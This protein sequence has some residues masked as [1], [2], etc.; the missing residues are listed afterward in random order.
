MI[1]QL[2][3]MLVG[4][5]LFCQ[6]TLAVMFLRTFLHEFGHYCADRFYGL[7][8]SQFEIGEGPVRFSWTDR[9]GTTWT[10]RRSF[11]GGFVDVGSDTDGVPLDISPRARLLISAAGPCMDVVLIVALT[12]GAV[13]TVI[14]LLLHPLGNEASVAVYFGQILAVAVF[15]ISACLLSALVVLDLQCDIPESDNGQ[16]E[17]ASACLEPRRDWRDGLALT[18]VSALRL[19]PKLVLP[20]GM[21]LAGI[22]IYVHL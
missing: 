5:A 14:A 19:A 21:L 4:I 7:P 18:G 12:T 22:T 3:S 6:A 2:V 13:G 8:V 11:G 9:R 16:M 17:E 15:S 1:L 10:L 20:L